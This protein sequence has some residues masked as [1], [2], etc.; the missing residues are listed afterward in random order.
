M[1][2]VAAAFDRQGKPQLAVAKLFELLSEHQGTEEAEEALSQLKQRVP[3]YRVV[4]IVDGDTLGILI[5]GE[6]VRVRLVGVDTPETVHP[7]KPVEAFGKEASAFAKE[8]LLD[9]EVLVA[10]DRESARQDRYGRAL[11]HVYRAEDGAFANLRIVAEG[12][13]HTYAQF[14]FQYEALFRKAERQAREAEKGLWGHPAA[15]A[16]SPNR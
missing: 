9:K 5:D 16:A 3:T 12:H 4:E 7:T 2:R 8:E 13:G 15:S 10:F 14:P 11:Y 6:P 1:L